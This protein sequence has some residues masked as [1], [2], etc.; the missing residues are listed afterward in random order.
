MFLRK[1]ISRPSWSRGKLMGLCTVD[2]DCAVLI[3]LGI[4][5]RF[6]QTTSWM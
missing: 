6:T 4:N 2:S 5:Y 3:G 1:P